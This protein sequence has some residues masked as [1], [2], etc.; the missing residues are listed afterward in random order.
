LVNGE[1]TIIYKIIY[2]PVNEKPEVAFN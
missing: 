2:S 1:N